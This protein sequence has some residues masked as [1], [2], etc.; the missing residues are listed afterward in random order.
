[1]V[2][3]VVMARLV[4]TAFTHLISHLEISRFRKKNPGNINE[5]PF[6]EKPCFDRERE[7]ASEENQRVAEMCASRRAYPGHLSRHVRVAMAPTSRAMTE[8]DGAAS[9]PHRHG[10]AQSLRDAHKFGTTARPVR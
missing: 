7:S 5:L 4:P 9:S 10:R 3:Q 2:S 1:M 8:G 6:R